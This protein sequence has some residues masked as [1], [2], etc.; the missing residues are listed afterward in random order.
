MLMEHGR[1]LTA[2]QKSP[3]ISGYRPKIYVSPDLDQYIPCY[4]QELIGIIRW[5]IE[6][7]RSYFY[8]EVSL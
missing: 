6:L 7:G 4:S 2:K 8:V 5:A 3:L 1:E